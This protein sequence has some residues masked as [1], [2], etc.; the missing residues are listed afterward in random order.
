MVGSLSRF[1]TSGLGR[2]PPPPV[3]VKATDLG[4]SARIDFDRLLVVGSLNTLN[5]SAR[6][7]NLRHAVSAAGAGPPGFPSVTITYQ[8]PGV[9]DVGR[10][11]VTYSPPPF[12]VVGDPDLVPA[13]AFTDYPITP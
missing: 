6:V 13:A 7:N 5:W 1:A 4:L 8:P 2:K 11:V 3:P 12:D 9:P 10:P